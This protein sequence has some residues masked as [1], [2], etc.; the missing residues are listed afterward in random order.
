MAINARDAM[1]DSGS[2]LIETR[3][4]F[5]D[6][7]Y[8]QANFDVVPGARVMLAV[9][10]TGTGMSEAIRDHVFE[11]FFRTKDAAISCGSRA[12]CAWRSVMPTR[13]SIMTPESPIPLGRRLSSHSRR[14]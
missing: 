9:S 4:A 2:L 13:P 11:P 7:A 12:W 14:A 8:A 3:N 6:E 5:L 1:P 10:D